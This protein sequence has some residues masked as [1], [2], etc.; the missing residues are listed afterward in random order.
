[1]T[2]IYPSVYENALPERLREVRYDTTERDPEEG[3]AHLVQVAR[4]GLPVWIVRTHPAQ[5]PR[6]LRKVDAKELTDLS[7]LL[8]GLTAYAVYDDLGDHLSRTLVSPVPLM[9]SVPMPPPS[10]LP[11]PR[12][13]RKGKHG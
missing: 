5:Q 3:R 6:V 12:T 10:W 1:M 4:Q 11:P 2:H 13:S 8:P 7:R 9:S